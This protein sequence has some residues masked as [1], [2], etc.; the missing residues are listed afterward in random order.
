MMT[1]NTAF[2]LEHLHPDWHS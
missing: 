2:H 1:L